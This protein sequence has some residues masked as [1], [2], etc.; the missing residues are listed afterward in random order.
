MDKGMYVKHRSVA[1]EKGSVVWRETAIFPD[2]EKLIPTF[3][4]YDTLRIPLHDTTGLHVKTNWVIVV[5]R[6]SIVIHWPPFTTHFEVT[7]TSRDF[8]PVSFFASRLKRY[9]KK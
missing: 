3:N 2:I 6:D 4:H 5:V 7:T 9:L 1:L 8:K